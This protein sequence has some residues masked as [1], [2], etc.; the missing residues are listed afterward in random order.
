MTSAIIRT[1]PSLERWLKFFDTTLKFKIIRIV[2]FILTIFFGQML[3]SQ[4]NKAKDKSS[5]EFYLYYAISG[6][7][8]NLGD[9]EPTLNINNNKF[10]YTK[11]Q[12]SYLFKR[13]KR[14]QF[15]CEGLFQQNSIDSIIS[16]VQGLK[17]SAISKVNP[18]I[19]SGILI[20]IIV[21]NGNDT[22]KFTLDNTFD[23][24]ALKI[25]DIINPYLPNNEKL[26]GS[27]KDIKAEEDCWTYLHQEQAKNKD[28]LNIKQ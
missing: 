27:L 21:A 11:E 25:I 19:M 20:S 15:I 2:A 8:S 1:S 28:S 18:C 23:Y 6:L 4:N 17:D 24:T 14:K 12:N 9:F 10:I 26:H 5:A 7:G 22:T 13:S 16:I 3:Y